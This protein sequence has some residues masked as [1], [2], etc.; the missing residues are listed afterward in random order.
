MD[1]TRRRQRLRE[2]KDRK[3]DGRASQPFTLEREPIGRRPVAR[4]PRF[5]A[6]E[7]DADRIGL[8][9]I[10]LVD[11]IVGVDNRLPTFPPRRARAHGAVGSSSEGPK[12]RDCTD[13]ESRCPH[14]W[15][16]VVR[17]EK[18]GKNGDRRGDHSRRLGLHRGDPPVLDLEKLAAMLENGISVADCVL[19]I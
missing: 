14:P 11:L 6:R 9:G 1:A 19:R 13:A 2:R 10:K 8:P 16:V 15:L 3:G 5:A 4:P 17:G 12:E 7:P 18:E